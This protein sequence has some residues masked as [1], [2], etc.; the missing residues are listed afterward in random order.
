MKVPRNVG[1]WR[2]EQQAP[3]LGYHPQ[4]E[5]EFNGVLGG[6]G[7]GSLAGWVYTVPPNDRWRVRATGALP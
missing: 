2:V 3:G 6:D 4:V 1:G 5:T 7:A